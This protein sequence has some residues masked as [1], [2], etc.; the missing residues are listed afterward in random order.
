MSKLNEKLKEILALDWK[1]E[2]KA[3]FELMMKNVMY[4]KLF[5]TKALE[6]DIIYCLDLCINEKKELDEI[7]KCNIFN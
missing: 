3:K 6:Q 5:L 4:Y 7:R 2:D 1:E